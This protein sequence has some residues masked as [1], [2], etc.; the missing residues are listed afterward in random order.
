LAYTGDGQITMQTVLD[1]FDAAGFYNKWIV[2]IIGS[3]NP[4]TG[5]VP[6][7]APWEPVLRRGA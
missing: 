3:Q 6:N 7:G 2:D 4:E 1:N 5:Y